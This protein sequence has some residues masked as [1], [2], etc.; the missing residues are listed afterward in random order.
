M[1]ARPVE[2]REL[3]QLGDMRDVVDMVGGDRMLVQIRARHPYDVAAFGSIQRYPHQFIGL[4]S[5]ALA[6]SVANAFRSD[7]E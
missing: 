4:E 2:Q 7:R 1:L 3:S 5:S 6:N